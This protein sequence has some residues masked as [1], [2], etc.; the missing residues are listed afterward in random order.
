[1]SQFSGRIADSSRGSVPA[2]FATRTPASADFLRPEKIGSVWP[3][4]VRGSCRRHSWTAAAVRRGRTARGDGLQEVPFLLPPP[5]D[6]LACQPFANPTAKQIFS[7]RRKLAMGLLAGPPAGR[8]RP[9]GRQGQQMEAQTAPHR[10]RRGHNS[11]GT[12]VSSASVAL[13]RVPVAQHSL[14]AAR[15]AIS[16]VIW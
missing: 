2:F 1:V 14:L 13:A 3:E 8:T 4:R 5:R 11:P 12:G 9:G 6:R 10:N 7:G 15:A 16:C